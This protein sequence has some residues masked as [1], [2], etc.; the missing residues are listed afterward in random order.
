MRQ[1]EGTQT[2]SRKESGTS[3]D[4]IERSSLGVSGWS[5]AKV[6]DWHDIEAGTADT[7]SCWSFGDPR[8]EE[9][10]NGQS[11]QIAK[12]IVSLGGNDS[13]RRAIFRAVAERQGIVSDQELDNLADGSSGQKLCVPARLRSALIEIGLQGSL[14]PI[15]LFEVR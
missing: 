15:N 7:S 10:I 2:S 13:G 14:A 8:N 5:V 3:R 6:H 1:R 11:A 9:E 12:L 4:L